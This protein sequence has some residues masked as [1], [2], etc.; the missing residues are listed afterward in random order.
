MNDLIILK[1]NSWLLLLYV[2]SI[3]DV[4]LRSKKK[5][6]EPESFSIRMGFELLREV[7]CENV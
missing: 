3:E 2:H 4:L 7:Q 1:W 6:R 5:G